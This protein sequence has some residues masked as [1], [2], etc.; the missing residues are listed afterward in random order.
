M[1]SSLLHVRSPRDGSNPLVRHH[2]QLGDR[3]RGHHDHGRRCDDPAGAAVRRIAV[4]ER[5]TFETSRALEYFTDKELQAQIGHGVEYWPVAI[6]REFIDN[7][8][9][10]CEAD[11]VLP[12]IEISTSAD[13]LVV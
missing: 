4:L 1:T 13:C 11:D 8:L 10:A 9:D 2:H 6:L 5:S 12:E 3:R 7:A